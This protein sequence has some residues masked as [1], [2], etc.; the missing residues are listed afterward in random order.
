MKRSVLFAAALAFAMGL[1]LTA[2]FPT[3]AGASEKKESPCMKLVDKKEKMACLKKEAEAK[4]A[5]KK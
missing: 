2:T 4:K 5:A 1:G 3:T